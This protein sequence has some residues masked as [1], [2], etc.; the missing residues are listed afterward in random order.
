MSID[1]KTLVD[2]FLSWKLP[3]TFYPDCFI[4][5]DRERAKQ[6]GSWPIG[7]N[8]LTA[9]QAKA[10]FEHALQGLDYQVVATI[11]QSDPNDERDG[12]WLSLEDK[13]R[14]A[15]LPPGTWLFAILPQAEA[16]HGKSDGCCHKTVT[17]LCDGCP[18]GEQSKEE[19]Q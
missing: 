16:Q 6:N 8:L 17:K 4:S 10:M 11:Q 3:E 12:L 13:H 19:K 18:Y 5:F 15:K 1:I 9:E 7:T 2:R 14:L